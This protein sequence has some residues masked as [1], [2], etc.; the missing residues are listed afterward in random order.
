V[1]G[2][3]VYVGGWF[4]HVCGNAACNSGNWDVNNIARWDGASWS[5]LGNGVYGF[6]YAL[7]V[8]GS[9]LYVGGDFMYLCD[10]ANCSSRTTL[11]NRIAQWDGV[12]WSALGSGVNSR[13][14]A[15]AASGSKLYVGG[16]FTHV[17]GG[18]A[19]T[20]GNLPVN[21]IVQWDGVSWSAFGN[22]VNGLVSALVM[23]GNTLS[24]GGWFTQ[25]CG[26][27]ACSSGNQI[28]N[29][30][31]QWNGANWSTLGSGVGSYVNALVMNENNL[32][33]GGEFTSAGGKPSYY[34][35]R[36]VKRFSVYLPLVVR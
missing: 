35:G 34:F 19:C 36:W 12:T 14:Y 10:N 3:N 1:S 20:Y 22:G 30:I 9:T 27:A 29:R 2:S 6:V 7:A 31:A 16:N 5:A 23:S 28:V 18:A 32:Y 4:W 13:V 24:V 33:V 15:L 25:V 8:S 21:N 17:C 26:N 11:V